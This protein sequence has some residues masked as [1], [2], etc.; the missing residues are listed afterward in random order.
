MRILR[1]ILFIRIF[2]RSLCLRTPIHHWMRCEPHLVWASH[3]LQWWMEI[4][5]HGGRENMRTNTITWIL[6]NLNK[7]DKYKNIW[8]HFIHMKQSQISKLIVNYFTC[9]S[10]ALKP[11]SEIFIFPCESSKRFLGCRRKKRTIRRKSC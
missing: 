9:S 11:K 3:P 1:E 8:Y 10:N 2:F 7:Y 4:R 5:R 6:T